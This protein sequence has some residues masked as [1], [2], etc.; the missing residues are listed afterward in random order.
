MKQVFFVFV[1]LV[2]VQTIFAQDKEKRLIQVSG[3]VYDEFLQPLP[4]SNIFVLNSGRGAIADKLGKFT[5]VAVE[6]DTIMFSSLGF[7]RSIVIVPDD[8][9]SPFFTRDVLLARDTFMIA[10][11]EVYPWRDYEEFKE[12]FLNLELP[13]DDLERARKNIALIKTQIILENT[14]T[15]KENF[16]YIMQQQYNETFTRGTYPTY[17]LFNVFAWSKFF[18]ALQDGDFKK[19]K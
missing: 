16:N 9:E 12:A 14:A 5:F 10:E 2:S 17:Q 15:P 13:D 7:K 8:L 4:Y 11:V 6:D 19:D 3:R 18:K 1:L